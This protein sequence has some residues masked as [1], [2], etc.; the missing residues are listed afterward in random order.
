MTLLHKS[1]QKEWAESIAK[2]RFPI[3]LV[4]GADDP[5]GDW[6]RGVAAVYTMLAHAGADVK[7]RLYDGYRHEILND[8]SYDEVM[9][10]ILKFI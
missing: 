5:V 7:L 9:G 6:G 10:D 3:L 2:K 8:A 1:N 4:S